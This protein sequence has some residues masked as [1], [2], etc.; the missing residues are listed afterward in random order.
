MTRPLLLAL[1]IISLAAASAQE[2]PQGGHIIINGRDDSFTHRYYYDDSNRVWVPVKFVA[3]RL[4]VKAEVDRSGAVHWG[5][6]TYN[7]EIKHP[8]SMDWVP[9]GA[10]SVFEPKAKFEK[11]QERLGRDCDLY[12]TTPE[13]PWPTKKTSGDASRAVQD[14][15]DAFRRAKEITDIGPYYNKRSQAQLRSLSY[16]E[17]FNFVNVRRDYYRDFKVQV[18]KVDIQRDSATVYGEG[19]YRNTTYYARFKLEREK[20]QWKVWQDTFGSMKGRFSNQ[21]P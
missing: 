5:S 20:G 11:S 9:L 10:I 21:W 1:V 6:K 14:F 4:G 18:T 7:V 8:S 17:R 15:L 16:D 19:K 12:I 2:M 3:E 13:P